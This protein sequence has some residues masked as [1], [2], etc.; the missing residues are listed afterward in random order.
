MVKMKVNERRCFFEV[1]IE[2]GAVVN[3]ENLRG[4][5]MGVINNDTKAKKTSA[6]QLKL[7]L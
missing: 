6:I 5:Q 1:F 2:F 4:L 3:M 7:L